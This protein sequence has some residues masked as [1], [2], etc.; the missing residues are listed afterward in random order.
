MRL[1]HQIFRKFVT[2]GNSSDLRIG[3]AAI[4]KLQELNHGKDI[5]SHLRVQIDAGGCHG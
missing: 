3:K 5:K 4:K 2:H 1:H